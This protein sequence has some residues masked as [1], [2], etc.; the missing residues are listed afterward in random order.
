MSLVV[1]NEN[2]FKTFSDYFWKDQNETG[3]MS[4]FVDK[5]FNYILNTFFD[6]RHEFMDLLIELALNKDR[7][8][9]NRYVEDV[10]KLTNSS[11]DKWYLL[12]EYKLPTENEKLVSQIESQLEMVQGA[13]MELSSMLFQ[14]NMK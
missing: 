2:L 6:S 5:N 3:E 9:Y 11:E 10:I 7:E 4:S 1:K 12:D 14:M 13:L 8:L